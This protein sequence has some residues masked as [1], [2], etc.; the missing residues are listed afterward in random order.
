MN[1]KAPEQVGNKTEGK[2]RSL[3]IWVTDDLHAELQIQKG[4]R[5]ISS[6]SRVAETIL[7]ETLIGGEG[8]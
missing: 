5:R 4:K 8:E 6:M 1:M 7:E 2:L 3:L